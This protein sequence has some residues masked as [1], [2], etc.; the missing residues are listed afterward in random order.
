MKTVKEGSL[1]WGG[2]QKKFRVLSVVEADGKT[3]VHY[4]DELK[5]FNQ[6][7]ANQYSCYIESFLQR[8]RE[9]PE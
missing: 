4:R 5:G 7:E 8:F 6:T 9:L 3:W 2:D 1:W